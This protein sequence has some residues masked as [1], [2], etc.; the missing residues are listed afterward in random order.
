M[1]DPGSHKQQVARTEQILLA[2]VNKHSVSPDGEINLVL[3]VW[4]LSLRNPRDG[5]GYVKS[6]A[7]ENHDCVLACGAGDTP[8][9]LRQMENTAT[10]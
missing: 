8:F 3:Y 1:L 7:L 2:V 10:I 4:C 6:A 5:K 9:G